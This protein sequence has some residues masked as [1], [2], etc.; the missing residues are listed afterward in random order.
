L[1]MVSAWLHG[2]DDDAT[3]CY[4]FLV[5]I[6]VSLSLGSLILT[7]FIYSDGLLL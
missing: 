3:S 1:A 5:V 4:R 6:V 7:S 2:V